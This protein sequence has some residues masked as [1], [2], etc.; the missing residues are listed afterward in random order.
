LSK[1]YTGDHS[2]QYFLTEVIGS[3]VIDVFDQSYR[4]DLSSADTTLALGFLCFPGDLVS[5][6]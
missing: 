3:P 2:S 5:R 4:V 1:K 6:L